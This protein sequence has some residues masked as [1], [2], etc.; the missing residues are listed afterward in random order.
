[1]SGRRCQRDACVRQALWLSVTDGI[2]FAVLIGRGAQMGMPLGM[3]VEVAVPSGDAGLKFSERFFGLLEKSISTGRTYRGHRDSALTRC[4]KWSL[5]IHLL[6]S[7]DKRFA[8]P[9]FH[10][11]SQSIDGLKRVELEVVH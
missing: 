5:W 6:A 2:P 8:G 11:L 3:Q 9:A 10:R 7:F 4:R 1:M